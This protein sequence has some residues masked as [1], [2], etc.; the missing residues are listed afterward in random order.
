MKVNRLIE[1]QLETSEVA[2][3]DHRQGYIDF[4]CNHY[5]ENEM[6]IQII[7]SVLNK[8]ITWSS[9]VRQVAFM[10]NSLWLYKPSKDIVVKR[11]K[12]E[13]RIRQELSKT[14]LWDSF[15]RFFKK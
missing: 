15:Y 8:A 4:V 14:N 12:Q 10:Q 13:T 9:Y 5:C 11:D 3:N 6:E 2:R 7:K 1:K